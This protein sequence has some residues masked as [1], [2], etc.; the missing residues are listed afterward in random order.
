MRL[1]EVLPG[2]EEEKASPY[3]GD[4]VVRAVMGSLEPQDGRMP[5]M[6]D[7]KGFY[8]NIS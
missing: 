2:A 1:E 8:S 6:K 4:L 7:P 5:G 3:R